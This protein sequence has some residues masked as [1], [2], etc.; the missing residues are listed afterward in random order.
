MING[1]D[2]RSLVETMMKNLLSTWKKSAPV[3]LGML[4]IVVLLCLQISLSPSVLA[5]TTVS[6]KISGNVRW[7]PEKS[8]YIVSG[9]IVVAPGATLT[10][11]SGTE[12]RFRRYHTSHPYTT[13][14]TQGVGY[15][16]SRRNPG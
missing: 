1:C 3:H 16:E 8:P 14:G 5:A 13:G 11:A 6:G 2:E 12:V 4:L 10:I 9:D 15:F 7:V